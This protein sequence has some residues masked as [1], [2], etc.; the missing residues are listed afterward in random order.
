MNKIILVLILLTF[1]T[2]KDT[3]SQKNE[4]SS[5]EIYKKCSG[6]CVFLIVFKDDKPI[7]SGSGVYISERGL[8]LTNYHVVKGGNRVVVKNGD[9]I[10]ELD[11]L[12]C[13]SEES[14][15]DLAVFKVQQGIFSN[16]PIGNSDKISKGSNIYTITSP[17]TETSGIVEN[18]FAPGMIT[19]IMMYND[20]IQLPIRFITDANVYHGSSG[21]AVLNKNGE[22]I[23]IIVAGND[24][25]N[26]NL[27]YIIPINLIMY[28]IEDGCKIEI[29]KARKSFAD[30]PTNKQIEPKKIEQP[31]GLEQN[32]SEVIKD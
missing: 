4:I 20:S 9:K 24:K 15:F 16:V 12:I 18:N 26:I 32:P 2:S 17:G 7:A 14:I 27:N 11:N 23:G 13:K 5:E 3:F 19:N 6:A 29:G 22:L 21:G 1:S 25:E 28:Y 30:N 10:I 31:K 8:I